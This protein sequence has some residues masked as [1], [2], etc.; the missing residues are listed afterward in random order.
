MDTR[1]LLEAAAITDPI[2]RA[3]ALTRLMTE[4]QG[5][6][7]AAARYRRQALADARDAGMTRDQI[8]AA[9]GVSAPRITQISKG[10]AEP[11]PEL[12][13][14]H[15]PAVLVQRAVPTDPADR[16]S[17]SL[18]LAEMERQGLTATREIVSVQTEPAPEQ[19]ARGLHLVTGDPAI[20]RRKLQKVNGVPV[21]MPTSWFRVDLF[22]STQIATD[23]DFVRPT[24]QSALADLGYHFGRADEFLISRRPTLYE[25]TKLEISPDEWVV[26][27]IRTSYSTEGTPVHCLETICVASRHIFP[28][29][30]VA[31]A[32]EF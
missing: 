29:G 21:R 16:G 26:Q 11:A 10:K 6:N 9:L 14:D 32:D 20:A 24:L 18:F 7:E 4:D 17:A 28:I 31:G 12:P 2:K 30:Q 25:V 5:L 27:I 19:V 15:A 13:A 1:T 23:R 22:D 8:A 3:Q